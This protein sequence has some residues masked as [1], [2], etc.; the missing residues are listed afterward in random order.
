[1]HAI[2]GIHIIMSNL[3]ERIKASCCREPGKSVWQ[4]T[5]TSGIFDKVNSEVSIGGEPTTTLVNVMF[6]SPN[7]KRFCC[8]SVE[9]KPSGALSG[10]EGGAVHRIMVVLPTQEI[11]SWSQ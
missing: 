1:M 8:V 11:F 7:S 2:K 5:F 4:V 3:L 6:T 9:A 10:I